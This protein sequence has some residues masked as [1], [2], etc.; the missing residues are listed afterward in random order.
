LIGAQK[1]AGILKRYPRISFY[2]LAI[3][4]G[5]VLFWF[6]KQV[7]SGHIIV[8][9]TLLKFGPFQIRWYGVLIVTG[10]L[11]AYTIAK[12]RAMR[13]GVKEDDLL[14]A[15]FWGVVS[16]IVCARLYYVVFNWEYYSRHL[17]EIF[18]TWH[19]GL[20]IHG[21]IL[22]AV[23][24][25]FLYTRFKKDVSFSF[26]QG[27]DLFT[28]VLPLA[29]AL[30]RWGNFFNYEAYGTPTDLPWKMF[31]PPE[32]RMIGYERFEYFHPTFLYESLWDLLV[33]Y[34]VFN[35]T[36]RYRK[37]FGETTALYFI[38]Y[39]LGRYFIE[40]LRLDSLYVGGIRTA[41]LMSI[42]LMCLGI[43]MLLIFRKRGE[44]VPDSMRKVDE[45]AQ[46]TGE[47]KG[48]GK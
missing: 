11:L 5:V 32:Y 2:I 12:H 39:S 34:L 13:E 19:G 14:G 3:V 23:L 4:G 47:G 22:G 17:D 21:A 46:K 24:S 37:R 25:T 29:Q 35:Y 44:I 38:L 33:F 26:M 41:Q 45:N 20:A 9:G 31:V 36:R 16:G 8:N 28:S 10:I 30:G 1:G 48:S 27:L 18:K 42:L 6:L 40:G 43:A 15:L 7:F